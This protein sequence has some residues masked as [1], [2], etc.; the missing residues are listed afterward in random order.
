MF[1]MAK[2]SLCLPPLASI[3][4]LFDEEGLVSATDRLAARAAE[5]S[6]TDNTKPGN[7]RRETEWDRS[8]ALNAAQG[9]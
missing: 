1:M 9:F 4:V 8:P 3:N 2:A 7:T 5:T 6:R